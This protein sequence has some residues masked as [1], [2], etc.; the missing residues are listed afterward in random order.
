MGELGNWSTNWVTMYQ[1]A[2]EDKYQQRYE[3][4]AKKA[5][6]KMKELGFE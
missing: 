2:D 4:I 5:E 6:E 3:E 1:C